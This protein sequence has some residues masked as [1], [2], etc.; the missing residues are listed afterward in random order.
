MTEPRF[1]KGDRV[2]AF[3][4]TEHVRGTIGGV[5]SMTDGGFHYNIRTDKHDAFYDVLEKYVFAE[6]VIDQLANVSADD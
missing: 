6:P 2:I 3:P 5:V 4:D 1:K